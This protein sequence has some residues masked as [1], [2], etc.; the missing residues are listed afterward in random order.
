MLKTLASIFA[1]ITLLSVPINKINDVNR[2]NEFIVEEKADGHYK[3]VGVKDEYLSSTELRIYSSSFSDVFIDEIASDAFKYCNELSSLMI[4]YQVTKVDGLIPSETFKTINYTGNESL[5]ATNNILFNEG[6]IVNFETN[7]EGFIYKWVNE[8]RPT[9]ESNLCDVTNEQY[10]SLKHLYDSLDNN[11]KEIVNS[12]VDL[13]GSKISDS[14]NQLKKLFSEKTD[15][16]QN[17]KEPSSKT[18]ITLI[19]V[20]A[21]FGM[22][23]IGAFYLLKDKNIIE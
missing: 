2:N 11:D 3:I 18:M 9:T 17:R 20:I 13:A 4:S 23:F 8:V 5:L 14:M 1:I 16:T 7:D 10:Q 12:Y 15:D 19:L 22:T 21:A 6:F